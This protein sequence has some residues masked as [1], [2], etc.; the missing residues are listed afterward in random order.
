MKAMKKALLILL[1]C[2]P[3]LIGWLINA[4]MMANPDTLPPLFFISIV[5]LLAWGAVAF[6][7]RPHFHNGKEVVVFLNFVAALDLLLVCI[8]EIILG[9]YWMN[10][11]G[12]WTQFYYLPLMN[13]GFTLTAWSHRVFT[14]YIA[15]FIL[16]VAVSTLGCWLGK[17]KGGR[18][19]NDA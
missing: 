1:G 13:I 2:I 4:F 11:I 15:S 14:A 8:Q 9:A 19:G 5:F 6:I 17:R 3:F 10:A 18:Q 7:A 12:G 16:M